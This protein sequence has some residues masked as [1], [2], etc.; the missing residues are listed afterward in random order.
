MS[1]VPQL[2]IYRID[3]N[4]KVLAGNSDD[5]E[6][7]GT[8]FDIIGLHICVPGDKVNASFTKSLTIRLPE[9]DKEDE[10]EDIS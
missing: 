5:R 9:K 10:V 6:A 2:I 1:E 7:L 3:K 4:S 8:T